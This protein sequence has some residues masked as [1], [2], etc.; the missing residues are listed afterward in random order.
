MRLLEGY[1]VIGRTG[2]SSGSLYRPRSSE[3][4]GPVARTNERTNETKNH[5]TPANILHLSDARVARKA[6]IE[7]GSA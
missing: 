4:V 2:R 3:T 1:R 7:K 6:S 5:I